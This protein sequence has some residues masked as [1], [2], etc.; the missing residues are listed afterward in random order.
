MNGKTNTGTGKGIALHLI[1]Y[2]LVF[3]LTLLCSAQRT[4]KDRVA[5]FHNDALG[6]PV[7]ATARAR[8]ASP[9]T[10]SPPSTPATSAPSP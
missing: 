10:P 9:A 8:R 3:G 2:L 7:A 1:R 5:Y 4:A 6:S